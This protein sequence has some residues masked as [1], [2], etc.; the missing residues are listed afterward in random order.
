MC[1][2]IPV[3]NTLRREWPSTNFTWILGSLEAELLD[4]LPGVKLI[5]FDKSKGWTAYRTLRRDLGDTRFS[6]LLHMQMALRASVASLFVKAP[7]RVGF[8]RKRSH[9]MQWLFTNEKIPFVDGQHVMDSFFGFASA[10]GIKQRVLNWGIPIPTSARCEV[11]SAIPNDSR[12]LLVISP[13][14]SPRFRNWRDWPYARY[15]EVIRTAVKKLGWQV[16][17]SGGSSQV[18]AFAASE[19]LRSV[20]EI[21]VLNL[22]GKL[23]IKGLLALIDRADLLI[24][25]DSG[26]VHIATAVGT[27][28]I[29]LY[30]TTNPDRAGPYFSQQWRINRYPDAVEAFLGKSVDAVNWG[31]RVRH[32][33]AMELVDTEEVVA[34]LLKFAAAQG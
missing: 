25:P 5:A 3:V 23:T 8:D 11:Q 19:I 9:D 30:A 24:S 15:A 29:G 20:P 6:I 13:C 27:P 18:E 1:H 10:L 26:P 28:V 4:G 16:A 14:A 21:E 7:I 33:R 34:M 31:T 2:T 12:P 22:Q 32:P 17:I